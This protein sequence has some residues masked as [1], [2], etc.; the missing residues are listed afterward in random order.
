MLLDLFDWHHEPQY[1]SFFSNE[2]TDTNFSEKLDI[3]K[4]NLDNTIFPLIKTGGSSGYL[5]L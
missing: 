3:M 1:D 5:L 2:Q 4:L